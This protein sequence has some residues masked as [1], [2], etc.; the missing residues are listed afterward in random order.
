MKDVLW[1][2]S[3]IVVLQINSLQC[4]GGSEYVDWEL[5]ELVVV[6]YYPSDVC[7]PFEVA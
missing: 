4:A 7:Q 6:E 2:K 1:Q 5:S 3:K